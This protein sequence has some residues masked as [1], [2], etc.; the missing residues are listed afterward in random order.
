[1]DLNLDRRQLFVMFG[2]VYFVQGVIQAYQLNF[3]KPHMDSVGVDADRLA[4]VATL[5]IVPFVIKW[6][7]GLISD[8][9]PL[10]G[11]GHRVPYM[12]IGITATAVAFA[13]AYFIDPAASFGVLAVMVVGATFFMALFDT[14]ADALSVDAVPPEDHPTVQAWMNGGRAVGL[15]AVSLVLGIVAEAVGYQS[16]FLVIALLMFIPLF[17]VLRVHEPPHHTAANAFDRRAFK[18][19]LQPRYLLFGVSLIL[20]WTFF[21]GI[22]GLITFYMADELGSSA[23]T[24]GVYGTLKGI[25]LLLGGIGM[26]MAVK[27]GG[28]RAST[29]ATVTLVTVGGLVFSVLDTERA[30]LIA[31]PLWGLAVG[32]QWTNYAAIAMSITDLRIAGSMFA[33]LQTMSNIGL[34]AGEGLATSLS[35]NLGYS[36]VFRLFGLANVAVIPL[37]FLVI[38]RFGDRPT[39]ALEPAASR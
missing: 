2:S 7:F 22:E 1:M 34:A 11:R 28:R 37:M 38:R 19:L 15:V 13:I 24:L 25:G 29:L 32:F 17:F 21:Q 3:F 14:T 8:K 23:S 39:D 4:I 10:W 33:I 16:L 27:G 26:S 5:G 35:D 36:G 12:I 6:I 9:Y 31:A 20:A 18:V 30:I